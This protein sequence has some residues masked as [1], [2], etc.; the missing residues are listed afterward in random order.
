MERSIEINPLPRRHR[1]GIGKGIGR[2][3]DPAEDPT[4]GGNLQ[5]SLVWDRNGDRP[6]CIRWD[7]NIYLEDGDRAVP[8]TE[9]LNLYRKQ[10][11]VHDKHESPI[12]S[13]KTRSNPTL[14][15]LVLERIELKAIAHQALKLCKWISY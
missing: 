6:G 11:A 2:K 3:K 1:K 4:I 13:A 9:R 14:P 12:N 7:P 5:E 15:A 8:F 10:K